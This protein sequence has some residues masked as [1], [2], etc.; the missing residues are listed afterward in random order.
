MH[1]LTCFFDVIAISEFMCSHSLSLILTH[2]LAISANQKLTMRQR[3]G[4]DCSRESNVKGLSPKSMHA[5]SYICVYYIC[6]LGVGAAKLTTNNL[7][8]FA[9]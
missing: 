9:R 7:G 1:M 8:I 6:Y 5:S 2:R 3:I 4:G